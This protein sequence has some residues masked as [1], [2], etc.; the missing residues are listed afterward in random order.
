MNKN[1]HHFILF[2]FLLN[3]CN[4]GFSQTER[5]GIT[6][7]QKQQIEI[8]PSSVV[9][10]VNPNIPENTV[11]KITHSTSAKT[12]S[13]KAI[14]SSSGYKLNSTINVDNQK[15]LESKN[16]AGIVRKVSD[17]VVAE[18]EKKADINAPLFPDFNV[19]A[20][21]E[22][23]YDNNFVS[24][25]GTSVQLENIRKPVA[26]DNAGLNNNNT[27]N[28]LIISP[29]KRKFL[30]GVA[31]ELEKEIQANLNMNSIDLQAKKK[32][33]QDLKDLLSK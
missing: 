9:I 22:E 19:I 3:F 27:S 26:E 21:K 14:P 6:D 28:Q 8:L 15:F 13:L 5:A 2:V 17:D 25:E 16:N 23:P 24:K 4:V 11:K 12:D 30:E 32:E 33:L 1:L 20:V 31:A 7:L 18:T 10:P 29:S